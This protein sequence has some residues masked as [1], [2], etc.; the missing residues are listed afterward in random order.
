[1]R[2]ITLQNGVKIE[3]KDAIEKLED[4]NE[5]L[6]RFSHHY[7][8]KILSGDGFKE[9]EEIYVTFGNNEA[10]RCVH[11]FTLNA[12]KTLED[13]T[14]PS[15][16]G[17]P[18]L[19]YSGYI[20]ELRQL[21]LV[22]TKVP[23][24]TIEEKVNA[25]D[26]FTPSAALEI[27]AQMCYI[28]HN[29]HQ[30]AVIHGDLTPRNIIVSDEEVDE[31]VH[32]VHII[33]YG[34]SLKK[35]KNAD[36]YYAGSFHIPEVL[37]VS[38]YAVGYTAQGDILVETEFSMVDLIIEANKLLDPGK[39]FS[40]KDV[41]VTPQLDV[42]QET[43]VFCYMLSGKK[44]GVLTATSPCEVLSFVLPEE[45]I[46][47]INNIR[48]KDYK[49]AL[50]IANDVLTEIGKYVCWKKSEES[51]EEG[52]AKE[53]Y[54]FD[55]NNPQQSLDSLLEAIR[56]N[57]ELA[58]YDKLYTAY[59]AAHREA[60]FWES[61]KP[62]VLLSVDAFCE[63]L[64]TEGKHIGETVW[65]SLITADIPCGGTNLELFSKTAAAEGA[66]IGPAFYAE[67]S[68][69]VS[70]ND[71]LSET[72]KA[73]I[74]ANL[75]N[76]RLDV[77]Y[78]DLQTQFTS[79]YDLVKKSPL[80]KKEDILP[81][82]A[83][84][85]QT[86]TEG[87]GAVDKKRQALTEI[88]GAADSLSPAF[89]EAAEAYGKFSKD[90]AI[91]GYMNEDKIKGLLEPFLNEKGEFWPIF[92]SIFGNAKLE[93]ISDPDYFSFI[94]SN[95]ISSL[96]TAKTQAE[97]C[98][99]YLGLRDEA[100][101]YDNN[102]NLMDGNARVSSLGEIKTKVDNLYER[103]NAH[104]TGHPEPKTDEGVTLP[105]NAAWLLEYAGAANTLCRD[106]K[107]RQDN[108]A[109]IQEEQEKRAASLLEVDAEIKN[110]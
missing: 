46:T 80:P 93:E 105:N 2:T 72:E 15:I 68:E 103:I 73:P 20:P 76:A 95:Y 40:L 92:F 61:G 22:S 69:A 18:K 39:E 42:F 71:T 109:R 34:I 106:I 60:G 52:A 108:A 31:K 24:Q 85:Q 41:E 29:F 43:G 110:L 81:P 63:K 77:S 47:I 101:Q 35:G 62:A 91:S 14:T 1:M 33:D 17:I 13:L 98:I 87:G 90:A 86:P 107:T 38:I 96:Q 84:A 50:S 16:E 89:A 83:D 78:R 57:K 53:E 4:T 104:N 102:G 67:L 55:I 23:G 66:E 28:T 70:K 74:R 100:E 5:P 26:L 65:R 11:P 51:P 58:S 21:C 12:M 7:K 79:L 32:I 56:S 19:V 82:R 6:G 88:C 37:P 59:H 25:G 97:M 10:S 3:I 49:T 44:P 94:I 64:L 36:R 9:G 48:K 30:K 45:L 99:E 27:F 8:G 54:S 75:T